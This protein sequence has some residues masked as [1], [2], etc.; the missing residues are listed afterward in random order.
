VMPA[1]GAPLCYRRI[2]CGTETSSP[3][4]SWIGNMG[5]EAFAVIAGEKSEETTPVM[6]TAP[7]PLELLPNHLYPKPW[8]FVSTKRQ[9]SPDLDYLQLPT[10]SPYDLYRDMKSWYRLIDPALAD[11]A[12]MHKKKKVHNILDAITEAEEFHTQVLDSYYHPN[13]YAFYGDDFGQRSFGVCRWLSEPHHVGLSSSEVQNGKPEGS[14]TFGG[15][16]NVS[17]PNKGTAYFQH[18]DQ[19][20]RGD[21]TVPSQSGAGPSGKVKHLFATRGY[22]HQGSYSNGA[23]LALTQHLI[24]KIVQGVA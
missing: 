17:F 19:D 13:S 9:S 4:G 11:P 7:G 5:M 10:G 2:A 1:F 16:R 15:G 6:A 14:S 20:T 23:M 21:G 18:M 3:S 12:D 24:V 8:L 22:D